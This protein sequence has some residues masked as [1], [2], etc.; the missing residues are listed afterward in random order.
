M[1]EEYCKECGSAR[2]AKYYIKSDR[3]C[4]KILI[5]HCEYCGSQKEELRK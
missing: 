3:G 2:L 1:T 4:L 5:T